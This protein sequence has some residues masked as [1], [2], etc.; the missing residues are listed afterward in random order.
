LKF[1]QFSPALLV[2]NAA[3]LGAAAVIASCLSPYGPQR[4]LFPFWQA[5]DAGSTA[6]SPEMW[7]ITDPTT[8]AGI[9]VSISTIL[10][11]WGLFTTRKVPLWLILFSFFAIYISFKSFRFINMLAIATL[12]IYAVR[13]D[14]RRRYP[15]PFPIRALKD[16]A[17]CLLCVFLL[18]LDAFSYIFAYDEMRAERHVGMR[19]VRFAPALCELRVD[20]TANRVPVLCG[21]GI[22]S[23]LSFG[24]SQFR[25]LL[26]SGLSHFSDDTKRYF[27]FVWRNPEALEIALQHLHVNYLFL[28]QDT[29]FWIPTL[30]RL[31]DWQFVTCDSAGMIFKRTTTAA[32]LTPGQRDLISRSM[33]KIKEGGET[34]AAYEYSTLLD[35]P[36]QSLDIVEQFDG[37]QWSDSHFN[38]F[39][40]WAK[41]LPA[42]F[43]E[44]YLTGDHSHSFP[45]IDGILAARLGPDQFEKFAATNPPGPRPWFWK[46]LEAQC[47]LE[48]GDAARAKTVFDSIQPVPISSCTYY[49]LWHAVNGTDAA[50]LSAYGRW[51]TWDDAAKQLMVTTSSRLNDRLTELDGP[52]DR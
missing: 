45:V 9:L 6:L 31:P 19:T 47:A 1:R 28:N 10:L 43:V 29:F 25:P 22:G 13:S 20:D 35:D 34:G 50:D 2:R 42:S 30:H 7:P 46:A 51:E 11:L 38:Y 21:H 39:S 4:L 23:Y 18:F 12:F 24:D 44:K 26:D 33:E 27:F 17:L 32:P 36:A 5:A 16:A 52:Q 3:A 15:S 8:V 48:K 40:A 37:R 41:T 14:S 49:Q